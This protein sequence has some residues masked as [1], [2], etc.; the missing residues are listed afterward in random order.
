MITEIRNGLVFRDGRFVNESLYIKEGLIISPEE[1][2]R[3]EAAGKEAVGKEAAGEGVSGTDAVRILDADGM[4]ILPGLVDIHFHGCMGADLCD[5]TED[6]LS[7]MAAYELRHGITSIMP[8]GMTLPEDVLLAAFANAAAFRRRQQQDLSRLQKE[9]ELVGV[10]MEGPF[11][12]RKRCGAQDPANIRR[13]DFTLFEKLQEAAEG[14]IRIAAVAPETDGAIP[15]IRKIAGSPD[16]NVRISIAHT[17]ADYRTAASAI[18]AGARQLTHLYNAMPPLLHREPGPIGAAAD[19]GTVMA[20]LITDGIHVHP[21]AIRSAFRLFGPEHILFISDSM[22]AAGMPDGSYL[23]GGQAVTVSGSRAILT[24]SL[25][26]DGREPRSIEGGTLAGSVTNLYDCLRYAHFK[27]GIPLEQAIACASE[28]PAKAIGLAD[29]IGFLTPGHQA[30]FLIADRDLVLRK[31]Y[32]CGQL[33][34]FS[35]GC[36]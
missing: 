11:L 36:K 4:Y 2:F 9:A 22:R 24:Q 28:N 17:D 3:E 18:D 26:G 12:S 33:C 15:F 20:E 7:A 19:S 27:A 10:Y 30:D 1:V 6:A 29:R 25:K 13:P 14:L 16:G 34:T 8:A 23:L 21:S 32:K 5:G 35:D 31:V